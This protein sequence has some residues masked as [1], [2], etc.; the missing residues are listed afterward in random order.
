[1]IWQGKKDSVVRKTEYIVF[2]KAFRSLIRLEFCCWLHHSWEATCIQLVSGRNLCKRRPVCRNSFCFVLL[3]YC[4]I[5]SVYFLCHV[6]V[7]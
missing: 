5:F 6:E 7:N 3:Q 4:R 2:G 1:M